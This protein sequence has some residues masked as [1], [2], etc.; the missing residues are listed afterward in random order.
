[1][2]EPDPDNRTAWIY[3]GVSSHFK[4]NKQSNEGTV[5]FYRINAVTGEISWVHEEEVTSMNS[6]S[7]GVQATALLGKRSIADL[8]IIPFANTYGEKK[9]G[10]LIAFDKLTGQIRWTYEMSNYTWS[11]PVAVYDESG[12]AYVAVA[13]NK[14]FI[15]LIEGTT[16]RNL[17]SF[18]ALHNCEAS[19]AVWGN[20]LVIGTR[21]MAIYGVRI[22]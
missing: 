10:K 2:L 15:H 14:G 1:M 5:G 8:V 17:T 7:G 21:G 12:N 20:Y 22:Y 3:V 4:K 13:D 18:N 9:D 6:V 16:G 11:S 19:P